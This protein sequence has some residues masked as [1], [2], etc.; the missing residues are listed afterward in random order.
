MYEFKKAVKDFRVEIGE[1]DS[2]RLFKVFDRDGSGAIDYD[3]FLR[4]VRGEM[5][6][7]RKGL[8]KKAFAIMDKDKSGIL[9]IDDIKQVYNAKMH[10]DVKAGKKTEDEILGEFLDTFEMHY[11]LNVIS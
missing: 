11:S 7:F 6:E 1:S 3:E 8:C 5:N 2:E 4:G 10:P 9:N